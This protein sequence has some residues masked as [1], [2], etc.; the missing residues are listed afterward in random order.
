MTVHLTFQLGKVLDRAGGGYSRYRPD[1]GG[2]VKGQVGGAAVNVDS[3]RPGF[4]SAS[5]ALGLSLEGTF[6]VECS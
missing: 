4:L 3:R 5:Q 1:G 6:P 2:R